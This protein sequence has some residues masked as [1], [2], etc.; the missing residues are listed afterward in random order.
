M[1]AFALLPWHLLWLVDGETKVQREA[2]TYQI[3]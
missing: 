2:A 3:P 1:G